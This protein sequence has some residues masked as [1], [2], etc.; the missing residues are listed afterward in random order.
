[1]D[2]IIVVTK[3]RIKNVEII[4]RVTFAFNI[5]HLKYAFRN[6]DESFPGNVK[7]RLQYSTISINDDRGIDIEEPLEDFL[8]QKWVDKINAYEVAR[9]L[10]TK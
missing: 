3:I 8:P 1:M 5:K 2:D 10:L 9:K 6:F 4:E 7:K